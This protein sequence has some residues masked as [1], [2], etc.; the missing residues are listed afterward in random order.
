MLELLFKIDVAIF[1]FFNQTVSNTFF[2]IVLPF[3]TDLDDNIYFKVGM[4]AFFVALYVF[5]YKT[6]AFTYLLY[7]IVALSLSDFIGGKVKRVAERPRPYQQV[8]ING[9]IKRSHAKENRSFYSNHSSNSFAVATYTAAVIPGTGVFLIPIAA[10]VAYSRIYCGVH[11]PADVFVG[12]IM[13]I[14]L[15][16]FFSGFAKKIV[17]MRNIRKKSQSDK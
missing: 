7:L 15:G 12:S 2:D 1:K 11:Y 3:I 14:L 10:I 5:K 9:A 4:F 8:E 17:L 6:T 16:L 13:G